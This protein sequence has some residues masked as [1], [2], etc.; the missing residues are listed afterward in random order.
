MGTAAAAAALLGELRLRRSLASAAAKAAAAALTGVMMAASGLSAGRDE[1]V[2]RQLL[3]GRGG[4]ETADGVPSA[5]PAAA[6]AAAATGKGACSS[7][8]GPSVLIGESS[9]CTLLTGSGWASG[10]VGCALSAAGAP[11]PSP[12]PWLAAALLAAA[13]AAV[14]ALEAD[15]QLAS[16]AARAGPPFGPV[17]MPGPVV[18]DRRRARVV[19][20]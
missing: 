1:V 17:E 12:P 16:G 7:S 2:V 5:R 14:R 4:G 13:A 15:K 19:L 11:P 9:K 3:S 8:R 10:R 18:K 20:L 6:E